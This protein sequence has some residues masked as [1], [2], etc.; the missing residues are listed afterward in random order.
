MFGFKGERLHGGGDRG[1]GGALRGDLRLVL[2]LD[3]LRPCSRLPRLE[4][5]LKAIAM[6]IDKL[7]DNPMRDRVAAAELDQAIGIYTFAGGTLP[8]APTAKPEIVTAR[9]M[10]EE[11][12]VSLFAQT[13][14]TAESVSVQRI[15]KVLG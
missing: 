9:W 8:L 5:Y 4:V 11:L 13:L 7:L 1:F 14:G 6:R 10:L 2:P 12:R 3:R 15:K